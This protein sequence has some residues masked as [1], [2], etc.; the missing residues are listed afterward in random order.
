MPTFLSY[1]EI[2]DY[3][4]LRGTCVYL[5]DSYDFIVL[6]KLIKF[7]NLEQSL[8]SALWTSI[9]PIDSI[10]R[11]YRENLNALMRE[12]SKKNVS[13]VKKLKIDVLEPDFNASSVFYY[14]NILDNAGEI[15]VH[16]KDDSKDLFIENTTDRPVYFDAICQG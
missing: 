5:H 15:E 7:G 14:A 8:R 10:Q 6:E 3:L 11:K 12:E 1:L 9:C 13:K 16:E 4:K 2:S